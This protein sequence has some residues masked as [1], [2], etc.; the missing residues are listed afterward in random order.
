MYNAI[1]LLILG[2]FINITIQF[3]L[4]FISYTSSF[5]IYEAKY[6]TVCVKTENLLI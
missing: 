5:K 6:R 3:I 4:A 2:L 1:S